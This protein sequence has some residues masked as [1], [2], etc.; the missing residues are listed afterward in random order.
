MLVKR[1]HNQRHHCKCDQFCEGEIGSV[2]RDYLGARGDF[3]DE[4][5]LKILGWSKV[6]LYGKT[7]TNFLA[8]PI[9]SEG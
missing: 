8:N 6:C 7:R 3:P 1:S 5:M 2:M 9:H 4:V